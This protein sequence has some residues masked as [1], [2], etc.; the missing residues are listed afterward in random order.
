MSTETKT[1]LRTFLR[2]FAPVLSDPLFE[3]ALCLLRNGAEEIELP[4]W[5]FVGLR[6]RKKALLR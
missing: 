4:K 6:D 3:Y 2:D 1:D 5:V